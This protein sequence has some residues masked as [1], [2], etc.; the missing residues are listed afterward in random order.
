M[1]AMASKLYD[2]DSTNIAKS[3]PKMTQ[4]KQPVLNVLQIYQILSLRFEQNFQRSFYMISVSLKC[5]G[6]KIVWMR[7]RNK[8]KSSPKVTKK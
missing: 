8:T 5:N 7:F 4:K 1:C 3:S 2:S 6:I